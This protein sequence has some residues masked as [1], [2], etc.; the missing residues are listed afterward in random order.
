[1]CLIPSFKVVISVC[2]SVI[3]IF[4]CSHI[5]DV[6]RFTSSIF[7]SLYCLVI[8]SECI[9]MHS[10]YLMCI[11][12]RL[13]ICACIHVSHLVIICLHIFRFMI[14]VSHSV[15]MCIQIR[16]VSVKSSHEMLEAIVSNIEFR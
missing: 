15:I 11:S 1:M 5:I 13:Q 16:E 3:I 6:G 7:I 12:H 14:R 8:V 9:Q 2:H 4:V 10:K